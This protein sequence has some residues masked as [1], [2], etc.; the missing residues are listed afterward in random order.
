M[1][2]VKIWDVSHLLFVDCLHSM[3]DCVSV[4]VDIK[5]GIV[6]FYKKKRC[7]ES[8]NA[9]SIARTCAVCNGLLIP[10]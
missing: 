3:G 10:H 5:N 9:M 7:L 1:G 6:L 4:L 2:V 8:G